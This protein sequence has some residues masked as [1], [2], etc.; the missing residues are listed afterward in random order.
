MLSRLWSE[1]AQEIPTRGHFETLD[2]KHEQQSSLL[3]SKLLYYSYE[4]MHCGSCLLQIK[5][6]AFLHGFTCHRS[7]TH[8]PLLCI[9]TSGNAALRGFILGFRGWFYETFPLFRLKWF[10]YRTQNLLNI[11]SLK[12]APAQN[13]DLGLWWSCCRGMPHSWEAAA[14]TKSQ[15]HDVKLFTDWRKM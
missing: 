5:I 4:L 13:R 11:H 7:S 3:E 15:C 10:Q 2:Q 6:I 14:F 12:G 1:Q 9:V 8:S